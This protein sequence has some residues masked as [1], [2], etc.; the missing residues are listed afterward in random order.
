MFV[1]ILLIL[2]G[3]FSFTLV[4]AVRNNGNI[5]IKGLTMLSA[6]IKKQAELANRREL[7]IQKL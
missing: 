1:L 6:K 7:S 3:M 4:T 2:D 5:L